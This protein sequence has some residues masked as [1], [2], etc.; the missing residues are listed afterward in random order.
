MPLSAAIM[1]A[2]KDVC[3]FSLLNPGIIEG[4]ARKE[5]SK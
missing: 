2:A 1:L 4:C 5:K 3:D